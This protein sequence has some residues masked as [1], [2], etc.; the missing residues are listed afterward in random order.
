[1]GRDDVKINIEDERGYWLMLKMFRTVWEILWFSEDNI[2]YTT[3]IY[4]FDSQVMLLI[5]FIIQPGVRLQELRG[6]ILGTNQAN[7][8]PI[9]Q[10]SIVIAFQNNKKNNYFSWTPIPK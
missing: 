3:E 2:T 7:N 1:M 6:C 4:L 5:Q 10:N 8:Y 9:I